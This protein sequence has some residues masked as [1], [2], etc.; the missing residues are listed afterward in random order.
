MIADDR[1]I[2]DSIYLPQKEIRAGFKPIMP[3]FKG[4]ISESEV[5]QIIDY[6]KSLQDS[7]GTSNG[8]S[9]P[10]G[11]GNMGKDDIAARTGNDGVQ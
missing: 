6:I 11:N 10:Y 5:L 8:S 2:R 9:N 1:Y 3:T 4:R 7:N